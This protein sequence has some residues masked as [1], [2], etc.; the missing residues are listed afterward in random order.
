MR[1]IDRRNLT[2]M[3]RSDRNFDRRV[4]SFRRRGERGGCVRELEGL[5]FGEIAGEEFCGGGAV[6]MIGAK[7]WAVRATVGGERENRRRQ[8]G[9]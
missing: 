6:E 3:R 2:E 8:E 4:R 9:R 1:A 7:G 5:G